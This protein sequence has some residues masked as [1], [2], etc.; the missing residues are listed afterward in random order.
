MEQELIDVLKK[1]ESLLRLNL[2]V[3]E[4]QGEKLI[5]SANSRNPEFFHERDQIRKD[6]IIVNYCTSFLKPPVT[7]NDLTQEE[8][9]V[10]YD[11]L[12]SSHGN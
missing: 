5:F 9:K 1:I 11:S 4:F 12:R 8:L 3:S 2:W 10:Y 6:M 7:L